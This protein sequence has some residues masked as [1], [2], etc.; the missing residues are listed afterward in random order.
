MTIIDVTVEV[1]FG[2]TVTDTLTAPDWTDV[3]EYVYT[4]PS[5]PAVTVRRGR[6]SEL[7]PISPGFIAVT[8]DNA[9]GRFDPAKT[10]GPYYGDLVPGTPIR[11]CTTYDSV[12]VCVALGFI[13]D[14]PITF[15]KWAST[16]TVRAADIF[17]VLS[18]LDNRS[19]TY[20][21]RY[22]NTSSVGTLTHHYKATEF[23]W[24]DLVGDGWGRWDAAPSEVDSDVLGDGKTYGRVASEVDSFDHSIINGR[25]TRLWTGNVNGWPEG[26]HILSFVWRHDHNDLTSGALSFK[27]N[28]HYLWEDGGYFSALC[29]ATQSDGFDASLSDEWYFLYWNLAGGPAGGASGAAGGL[30][31]I[32]NADGDIVVFY[33]ASVPAHRDMISKELGKGWHTFTAYIPDETA[34]T[35][36][37]RIWIDGNEW[38]YQNYA[39]NASTSPATFT[40][41]ETYRAGTI[42]ND[43]LLSFLGI[44]RGSYNGANVLLGVQDVPLREP[45]FGLNG[46]IDHIVTIENV[47]GSASEIAAFAE[48]YHTNVRESVDETMSERFTRLMSWTDLS[49]WIGTVDD[50][51]IR[52]T[53]PFESVSPL[54]EMQLIEDTSRGKFAIQGDGTIDFHSRHWPYSRTESRNAQIALTNNAA[55]LSIAGTAEPLEDGVTLTQPLHRIINKVTVGRKDGREIVRVDQA[56]IDLYSVHNE[57][58]YTGLLHLTDIESAQLAEYLVRQGGDTNP[59]V[60]K[61][62]FRVEDDPT[63]LAE[64][65]QNVTETDLVWYYIESPYGSALWQG[66]AH[67]TGITHEFHEQGWWVYLDIDS[68]RYESATPFSWDDGA[69]GGGDWESTQL[70][71]F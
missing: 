43:Y 67:V 17:N 15:S 65:A 31:F 58:N 55:L 68:F 39:T 48:G 44:T 7:D 37:G 4:E 19:E 53:Y 5:G 30:W 41:D 69:G 51:G 24:V 66:Y 11:V 21:E 28:P 16:V 20:L 38:E 13:E 57:L 29:S 63:E 64:F 40:G 42:W 45:Q 35:C 3:T 14:W 54:R 34:G 70:W 12:E 32:P 62:G 59:L 18:S 46:Y 6:A 33:P 26:G 23:E 47:T 9:D 10:D 60:T 1:A 61:I 8:F 50:S 36:Q 56:S 2:K 22:I 27:G 71:S 52:T 49:H 25:L